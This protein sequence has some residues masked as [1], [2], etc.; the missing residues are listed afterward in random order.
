MKEFFAFIYDTVFGVWNESYPVIFSTLFNDY[1]Y[2]KLGLMFI[3]VPL[4]LWILFYYLWHY[5]YGRFFH[6]LLWMLISAVI[7]FAGSWGMAHAEIF[8]SGNQALQDAIAD[9]ASGYKNYASGLPSVYGLINTGLAVGLG[10]I[11]SLIFKQ[12]SKIQMHL[13]F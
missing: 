8:A 12:F 10:F 4:I 3:L 1:G 7:V 13:P 9:P 11:F 6:W 2:V 5:P